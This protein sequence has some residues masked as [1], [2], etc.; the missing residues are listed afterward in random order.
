VTNLVSGN[1]RATTSPL[2]LNLV[3]AGP[4][5]IAL[6][7]RSALLIPGVVVA[8]AKVDGG[9]TLSPHALLRVAESA[10]PKLSLHK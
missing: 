9:T 2:N 3:M 7:R 1:H 5:L 10:A 8:C 4:N 6:T